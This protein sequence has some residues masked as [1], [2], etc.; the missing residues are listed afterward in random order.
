MCPFAAF[1]QREAGPSLR[2]FDFPRKMLT[3]APAPCPADPKEGPAP[4]QVEDFRHALRR[5]GAA[6]TIVATVDRDG[7]PRGLM[8]TAVMSLSFEPPSMLL[9]INRSASA[10]PALLEHGRFSINLIGAGEE[11]ACRDFAAADAEN[12]FQAD[13]WEQ[14]PDRVP[15]YRNAIATIICD[16]GDVQ[17]FGTHAIVR[18]LVRSTRYT[19]ST[20]CLVYL[21]G[22]FCRTAAGEA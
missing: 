6:V 2:L 19:H 7:M 4:L 22:R 18:G 12:R 21:D 20:D 11:E 17:T 3:D 16:V 9:A 5:L 13:H 10:L 1:F 8:M 15:I 14:H